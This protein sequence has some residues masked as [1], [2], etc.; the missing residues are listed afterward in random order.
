MKV[1]E[2]WENFGKFLEAEM[3][4]AGVSTEEHK[5]SLGQDSEENRKTLTSFVFGYWF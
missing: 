3:K 4:A 2:R 5:G 1:L